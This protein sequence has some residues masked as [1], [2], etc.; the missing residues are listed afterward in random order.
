[1]RINRATILSFVVVLFSCIEPPPPA[2]GLGLIR[3]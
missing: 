2:N 1:M 3:R